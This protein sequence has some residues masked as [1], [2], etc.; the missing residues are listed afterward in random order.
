MFHSQTHIQKTL[1]YGFQ[2][3]KAQNN[4]ISDSTRPVRS[5]QSPTLVIPGLIIWNAIE[6]PLWIEQNE[7]CL[8]TGN[9]TKARSLHIRDASSSISTFYFHENKIIHQL[10]CDH[11]E[12]SHKTIFVPF[13]LKSTY[14]CL[15]QKLFY[16][17]Q[18]CAFLGAFAE[19][20]QVA[21]TFTF[22]CPSVLSHGTT[23]LHWTDFH[24]IL[25]LSIS[26]RSVKKT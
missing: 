15:W 6:T 13:L 14:P 5:S 4:T 3:N 9:Y 8:Q 10:N 11:Y 18:I 19:L 26:L 20:R 23:R 12:H 24:K 21:V 2:H 7:V 25:Y 17:L 22:V 1:F 16:K